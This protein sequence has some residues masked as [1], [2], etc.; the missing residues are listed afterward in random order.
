MSKNKKEETPEEKIE[1]QKSIK[2]KSVTMA[3]RFDEDSTPSFI[4]KAGQTYIDSGYEPSVLNELLNELYKRLRNVFGDNA[5]LLNI[6]L[7]VHD[8]DFLVDDATNAI[9][10]D[11]NGH[12]KN[13]PAHMHII[14]WTENKDFRFRYGNIGKALGFTDDSGQWRQ[15]RKIKHGK[16][17]IIRL[18]WYLTHEAADSI[19][20]ESKVT[21]PLER[22]FANFDVRAWRKTHPFQG[23]K[24]KEKLYSA[25]E[26]FDMLQN[27]E[28]VWN[29]LGNREDTRLFESWSRSRI[30]SEVMN[31][32][33]ASNKYELSL[34]NN[35]H[36]DTF[37]IFGDAGTGKTTFAKRLLQQRCGSA[38]YY[39]LVHGNGTGSFA[40]AFDG[41]TNQKGVLIDELR[42]ED[43][44]AGTL[45]NVLNQDNSTRT[46]QARYA[47]RVLVNDITVLTTVTDVRR[48]W[49]YVGHTNNTAGEEY[50]FFR[51]LGVILYFQ[52]MQNGKTRVFVYKPMWLTGTLLDSI[53]YIRFSGR[54]RAGK[55]NFKKNQ[56]N[57]FDDLKRIYPASSRHATGRLMR[58]FY[59]DLQIFDC[60]GL[61]DNVETKYDVLCSFSMR[62]EYQA[63]YVLIPQGE[64]YF[65]KHWPGFV[66]SDEPELNHDFLKFAHEM[67]EPQ[68]P[69]ADIEKNILPYLMSSTCLKLLGT[70]QLDNIDSALN[71]VASED[72]DKVLAVLFRPL[73]KLLD[74]VMKNDRP[75]KMPS[76]D[77]GRYKTYDERQKEHMRAQD[78]EEKKF[79]EKL[80][81]Y[82]EP[83][84]NFE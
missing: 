79:Q 33:E 57:S 12:R 67:I 36:R 56:V 26:I 65:R 2:R 48:F 9:A 10:V 30:R 53:Q 16:N 73:F 75:V 3:F 14:I 25:R 7:A 59:D 81:N 6:A 80:K 42:P 40:G 28:I 35:V 49:D 34:N 47:N 52:R 76:V 37:F 70:V 58:G 78:E 71:G 13:K 51:R 62:N 74:K 1:N 54:G 5:G 61:A 69:S 18:N 72:I 19:E 21:Y 17:G 20:D 38:G 4:R 29:D 15:L 84:L 43:F 83:E 23:R 45:L 8:K 55:Y 50:Q 64:F 82:R 41:Y 27:G 77:F 22:V 66:S 11:E 44:S 63:P 60:V 39:E 24:K 31:M 32:F 46:V 68:F